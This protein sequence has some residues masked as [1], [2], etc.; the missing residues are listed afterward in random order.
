MTL[1]TFFSRFIPPE[2]RRHLRHEFTDLIGRMK[3]DARL[4]SDWG[5]FLELRYLHRRFQRPEDAT[6]AR[7]GNL[8]A[9]ANRALFDAWQSDSAAEAH[10]RIA[11]M[12]KDNLDGITVD[13]LLRYIATHL[14]EL[15]IRR[16]ITDDERAQM[17]SA[18]RRHTGADPGP[19][20]AG[21]RPLP[22]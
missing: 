21:H 20:N 5:P 11:A 16:G 10:G 7:D 3:T 4:S 14:D 18:F 1:T 22:V 6:A 8:R 2:T 12:L 19:Q 13:E 9:Y 15:Q 17:R